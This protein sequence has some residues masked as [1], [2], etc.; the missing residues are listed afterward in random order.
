M[1]YALQEFPEDTLMYPLISNA[2]RYEPDFLCYNINEK[3][4]Y[5]ILA[6]DYDYFEENKNY[7]NIKDFIKDELDFFLKYF[8]PN[9]GYKL[10]EEEFRELINK[11][12]KAFKI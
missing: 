1:L 10:T 5:S 9:Y 6:N 2:D 3:K 7:W 11:I 8:D 4:F 12:K